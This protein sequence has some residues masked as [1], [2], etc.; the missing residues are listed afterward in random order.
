MTEWHTLQIVPDNERNPFRATVT[1]PP[2]ESDFGNGYIRITPPVAVG[3]ALLKNVGVE[4]HHDLDFWVSSEVKGAAAT[5][6]SFAQ[7]ENK[8]YEGDGPPTGRERITRTTEAL[9][10][11]IGRLVD[12]SL[13]S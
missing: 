1:S 13:Y 2:A 9:L 12:G 8:L 3:E 7:Q 10:C 6:I 5:V 11:E 4:G